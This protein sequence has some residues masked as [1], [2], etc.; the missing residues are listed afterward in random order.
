M[1]VSNKSLVSEL[2]HAAPPAY[3][4]RQMPHIS[5]TFASNV[6]KITADLI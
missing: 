4:M 2:K 1:F 6:I 5:L 3:K